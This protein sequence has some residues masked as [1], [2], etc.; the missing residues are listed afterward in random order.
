MILDGIDLFVHNGVI[1]IHA[2]ILLDFAS[3]ASGISH[4]DIFVF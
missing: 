1:C 3:S 4:T 2:N